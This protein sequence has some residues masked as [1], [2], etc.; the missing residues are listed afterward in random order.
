MGGTEIAQPL[1][2]IEKRLGKTNPNVFMLTDG[3]VDKPEEIIK[4]NKRIHE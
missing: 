4:I 2:E 3:Q 1:L